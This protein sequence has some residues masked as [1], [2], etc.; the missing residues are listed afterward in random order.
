M[1]LP[2]RHVLLSVSSRGSGLFRSCP[3]PCL[4]SCACSL[5]LSKDV[6]RRVALH[7]RFNQTDAKTAASFVEIFHVT[8]VEGCVIL[9]RNGIVSPM[10]RCAIYRPSVQLWQLLIL[11]Q[12]RCWSFALRVFPL[13][14]PMNLRMIITRRYRTLLQ[15]NQVALTKSNTEERFA[16]MCA[17]LRKLLSY[18]RAGLSVYDPEHDSLKIVALYGP[19]ENS[20]FRPG[21]LLDRKTSQTG[22][23]FDH[24]THM[25]RRD[26]ANE[27]RFP[28][29]KL[30]I[31][32]G[33]RSLCSVPLIV[34]G[35]SIGVVTI[36]SERKNEF[37]IDQAHVVQEISNQIALSMSPRCSAHTNTKLVCPRCIGAAG[38]KTTVSKHREDL[39]SWGKKGGRGHKKPNFS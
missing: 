16:G 37:S 20:T 18:D 25:I 38:G 9:R 29:D 34:W 26:L 6:F 33:Y 17:A 11:Q 1:P 5:I 4:L 32:E 14:C 10:F 31:D 35:N 22:W 23:V 30:T 8:D 36:L 24:Q 3:A 28:A 27:V 15:V 13:S 39:S 12:S 19:H 2:G 21:R 7:Y